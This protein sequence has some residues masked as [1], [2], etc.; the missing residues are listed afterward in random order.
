MFKITN[1]NNGKTFIHHTKMGVQQDETI[2]FRYGVS[3]VVEEIDAMD[4]KQTPSM[5]N[6]GWMLPVGDKL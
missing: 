5:S 2:L 1:T 4:D 6:L 3:F